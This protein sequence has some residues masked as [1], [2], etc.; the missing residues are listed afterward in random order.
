MRLIVGISGASGAVYGIR[1]LEVLRELQEVEIHL[2]IS[3]AARRTIALETD[4]AL[5]AVERLA[6]VVHS[7]NDIAAPISSGSFRTD[8]MLVVPCSISTLSKI[9]VSSNDNLLVRAADVTLKERRRLVL[10]LRETPLHLGHLRLATQVAEIG[11]IVFPPVP[12]FY[13]RPSTI[14]HRRDCRSHRDETA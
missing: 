1:L 7:V 9:A 14:D 2:V 12:A 5:S 10:C 8:G 13:H 6:H 11:G 3:N 4:C